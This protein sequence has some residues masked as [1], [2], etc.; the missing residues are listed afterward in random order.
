MPKSVDLEHLEE[1]IKGAFLAFLSDGG[2][3]VDNFEAITKIK[4]STFESAL[5]H[6][7]KKLFQPDHTQLNNQLSLLPYDDLEVLDRLITIYNDLCMMCD[8]TNGLY[9]FSSLTGYA[10]RTLEGWAVDELNP[11]RMQQ[12]K[13]LTETRKHLFRNML[14]DDRTGRIVLANNDRE[15]GL[16]YERSKA[17]E[18]NKATVYILP[19]EGMRA[20]IEDRMRKA[21]PK[22]QAE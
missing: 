21:L 12:V 11:A 15:L 4:H 22:E 7:Y 8:K 16:E 5:R 19:G 6:V 13:K 14:S 3:D 2:V 17:Q 9:G 18:I 1:N 20:S 10:L